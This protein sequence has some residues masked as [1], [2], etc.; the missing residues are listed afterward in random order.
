MFLFLTHVIMFFAA[1][2]LILSYINYKNREELSKAWKAYNEKNSCH[3][4]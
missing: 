2:G 4:I 1:S 3:E